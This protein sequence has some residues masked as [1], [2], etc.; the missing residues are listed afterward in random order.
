MNQYARLNALRRDLYYDHWG[1]KDSPYTWDGIDPAELAIEYNCSEKEVKKVMASIAQQH[2]NPKKSKEKKL[3]EA[4]PNNGDCR[5]CGAPIVWID[6]H[7][8]DP[9]IV[10]G[11]SADGSIQSVRISHFATCPDADKWRK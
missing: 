2:P 3:A 5:S 8:C 4:A 7:P 1:H 6:K 9:A 11:V 10:K